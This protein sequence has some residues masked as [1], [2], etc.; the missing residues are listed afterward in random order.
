MSVFPSSLVHVTA[1]VVLVN[2]PDK[3]KPWLVGDS[4][5][6]RRGGEGFLVR[7]TY[8]LGCPTR[9]LLLCPIVWFL[10]LNLL[11]DHYYAL[12]LSNVH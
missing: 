4:V 2:D 3:C 6:G 12:Y 10:F 9:L 5:E 11:F 1:Q 8:V 7:L